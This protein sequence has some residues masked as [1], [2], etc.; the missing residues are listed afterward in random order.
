MVELNSIALTRTEA[1][2]IE[3]LLAFSKHS[4]M[5]VTDLWKMMDIVWDE[6]GCDN[7]NLEPD[8]I[9]EYYSHPIWTLNGLFIEQD[10]VS[11]GHREAIAN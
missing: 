5:E 1:Q 6:M 3:R 2:E 9:A 4:P 10:D 11:M 8:K 7:S